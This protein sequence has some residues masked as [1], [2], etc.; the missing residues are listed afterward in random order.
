MITIKHHSPRPQ[1]IT[2]KWVVVDGGITAFV[3]T[4]EGRQYLTLTE[5]QENNIRATVIE[6]AEKF[7]SYDPIEESIMYKV[8]SIE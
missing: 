7:G 2:G 6:N 1:Y 5:E 8:E 4:T 3:E